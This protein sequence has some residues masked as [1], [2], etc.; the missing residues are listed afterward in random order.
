M[1]RPATTGSGRPAKAGESESP[2]YGEFICLF[3]A[4][5]A[6]LRGFL[7]SL[8]PAW[9]DVDEV[10]QE[11]GIVAW[12]KFDRFVGGTSFMA[13]AAT[14]ARFEALDHLRRRSRER[15]VFSAAVVDA[16]T[17]EIGS[18]DNAL[19][20]ERRALGRCLERLEASERELLLLS[21]RPGARLAEVAAQS[22]KSVQA[23]YKS[24]Q[25]LRTRLRTCIEREL[26]N[27]MP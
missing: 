23:G 24:V 14:I 16:M 6:R 10:M 13:W 19:E 11:T 18:E 2:R 15:L 9:A 17:A 20:R 8:L 3:V 7:R 4:H 26:K 27:E 12:R 25:R 5:E 1:D 22:G 21:Y